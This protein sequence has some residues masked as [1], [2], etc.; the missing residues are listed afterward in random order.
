M[1]LG[2]LLRLL[3]PPRRLRPTRIG[4]LFVLAVLAI[5]G[6]AVNTGN[7]LLYFILGM[8]LGGIVISGILSERNLRGLRVERSVPP[9]VTAGVPATLAYVVR[10][11]RAWL[12]ILAL[13]L[14]DLP[15]AKTDETR[16]KRRAMFVRVDPGQTRR[17]SYVRTF[18][19]RGV[20]RLEETEAATT[21][22]FGLFRKSRRLGV[23][24]EVRVR[25]RIVDVDVAGILGG[26]DE[27]ESRRLI[28]GD[29]LEL[30]S[31]REH[32]SGDEARR[33]HWKATARA[34]RTM[35]K[36]PARDEP[37]AVLVRLEL[38]GY[39][40]SSAFERA[41]EKAASV[42]A[43]LL[44]EG[45][46][47]GLAAGDLVLPPAATQ[48]QLDAILDALVDVAPGAAEASEGDAP[49][50]V[51]VRIGPDSVRTRAAEGEA[52]PGERAPSEPGEH[53]REAA[54]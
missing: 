18:P 6:S 49:E 29:G 36:D 15:K 2:K 12:P 10:A 20:H 53:G 1:T 35:V 39:P 48:A 31:L 11:R 19:Q 46:A 21:F 26:G 37:P 41:V 30:F 33:I 45:F 28:R 40:S 5:G 44:G 4:W 14:E 42:A 54:G 3:E 22:P 16:E 47:V 25:P 51:V 34:G 43:A 24:S 8:T 27:G 50:I 52:R 9:T 38:S 17:R 32:A 13:E 7:N 23:A